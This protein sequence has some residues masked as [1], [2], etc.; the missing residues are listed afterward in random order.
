MEVTYT[1]ESSDLIFPPQAPFSWTLRWA[2]KRRDAEAK[3]AA[4]TYRIE[5]LAASEEEL[6][7]AIAFCE[8]HGATLERA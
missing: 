5:G 3:A 6:A 2:R 4:R 7:E 1:P 8:R